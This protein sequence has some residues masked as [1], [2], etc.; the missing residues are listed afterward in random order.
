MLHLSLPPSL[1]PPHPFTH[2]PPLL[3]LHQVA[4]RHVGPI[5]SLPLP[6]KLNPTPTHSPQPYPLALPLKPTPKKWDLFF[7]SLIQ[8]LSLELYCIV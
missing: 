2:V 7:G 3:L 1:H 4:Q 5:P 6:Q 8:Y